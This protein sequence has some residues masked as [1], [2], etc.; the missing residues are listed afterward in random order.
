[1]EVRRDDNR[2]RQKGVAVTIWPSGQNAQ[3]R[4]WA[5]VIEASGAVPPPSVRLPEDKDFRRTLDGLSDL[6]AN[7]GLRDIQ[8]RLLRWTHRAETDSLWRGAAAGIGGIG[9]TVTSQ[10]PEV[11]A[12]MKSEYDRLVVDLTECDHLRLDTE[13]VLAVGTKI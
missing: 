2:V 10:S 11:R 5:E 1:M 3:S 7:A 8:T 13:A 6:L 9:K 4:M 12:K